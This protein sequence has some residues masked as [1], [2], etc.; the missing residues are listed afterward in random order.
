[1][2]HWTRH[3]SI[4]GRTT[5][6]TLCAAMLA[7]NIWGGQQVVAAELDG[8]AIGSETDMN[9]LS[10]QELTPVQLSNA[11]AGT[12]FVQF[13]FT[14]AEVGDSKDQ[15]ILGYNVY[16]AE[17]EGG[18]ELHD[19]YV[20][21]GKDIKDGKEAVLSDKI[22]VKTAVQTSQTPQ[23]EVPDLVEGM[24]IPQGG[25]VAD[26][27]PG[28]LEVVDVSGETKTVA[29]IWTDVSN[30]DIS[31]PGSYTVTVTLEGW[32]DPLTKTV[33]VV[34]NEIK[35]YTSP[36]D[37]VVVQ[38]Q[39]LEG[40]LPEKVK[41]SYTNTTTGELAVT[42]DISKVD[43]GKVGTY[44][45]TG[46]LAT[47]LGGLESAPTITIKVVATDAKPDRIETLADITVK[48]GEKII[49]PENVNVI[50]SDG[51][52]IENGVTW[53]TFNPDKAGT[54]TVNGTLTPAIEGFEEKPQ[55]R[56]IVTT[57]PVGYE[58]LET[59]QVNKGE[60]PV[61]PTEVT[62]KFTDGTTKKLTV[63]WPE[64]DTSLVGTTVVTADALSESFGE[65]FKLPE[66]TIRVIDPQGEKEPLDF[67][68]LAPVSVDF[69]TSKAD[70]KTM[71]KEK[72]PTVTL[73]YSDG[74]KEQVAVSWD[75]AVDADTFSTSTKGTYTYT[76]NGALTDAIEG[77]SLQPS[78]VVNII[79][80]PVRIEALEA[81]EV[82]MGTAF[83]DIDQLPSEVTIV[84]ADDSTQ[85]AAVTW[86]EGNYD[87]ETEGEYELTGDLATPIDGFAEIPSI[88]VKVVDFI[89]SVEEVA[90]EAGVGATADEVMPKEV[91]ATW[92]SGKTTKVAVDWSEGLGEV[93]FD[94]VGTY[95]AT[96][97]VVGYDGEVTAAVTVIYPVVYQFDFGTEG[98]AVAEGWTGVKVNNAKATKPLADLG[99]VYS[100]AQGYGFAIDNK[101]DGRVDAGF[102]YDG[103]ASIPQNVYNDCALVGVVDFPVNLKNGKY[104]VEIISTTVSLGTDKNYNNRVSADVEG[105]RLEVSSSSQGARYEVGGTEVTVADNQ[106]N[107][108]FQN[109]ASSRVAGIIIRKMGET[110]NTKD[111]VG[112]YPVEV[113]KG[114]SLSTVLPNTVSVFAKGS[115]GKPQQVA[116]TWDIDSV[117]TNTLGD[118]E[119]TGTLQNPPAGISAEPKITVHVVDYA[120][121]VK[122]VYVEV[123]KD[124]DAESVKNSLPEMVDVVYAS[125]EIKQLAVTWGEVDSSAVGNVEVSG[126]LT[127]DNADENRN[128]V[129]AKASVS[130]AYKAVGR[131]DFGTVPADGWTT[132]QDSD[133]E[134]TADRKYGFTQSTSIILGS[135]TFTFAG[136]LPESVY[137]DYAVI[138]NATFQVDVPN[139]RYYVELSASTGNTAKATIQ[140]TEVSVTADA[141]KYAVNG[142]E[143]LVEN[144]H[145]SITF[146]EEAKVNSIVVREIEQLDLSATPVKFVE[147]EAVEVFING[148]PEL[149]GTILLEYSDNTQREVEVSWNTV[150][151]SAIGITTVKGSLKAPIDGFT[152]EPEIKVAVG[153][154]F[155]FGAS[156]VQ[157]GWIQ[158]KTASDDYETNGKYGFTSATKT[159]G[160]SDKS[161]NLDGSDALD[162]VYKDCVLGWN[163]T[164]TFEYAVKVPN[165]SYNVTVYTYNGSGQ[166]Y[167]LFTIEGVAVGDIRHGN[168]DLAR[169]VRNVTVEVTDG[170][171]NVTC[172]SSKSNTP[173]IYFSGLTVVPAAENSA[174]IASAISAL[175]L[176]AMNCE[177]QENEI[178]L[179]E[180]TVT[181]ATFVEI[182]TGYRYTDTKDV[183]PDTT[184]SYKV[185]AVV[186]ETSAVVD[187][188]ALQKAVEEAE[189]LTDNQELYTEESW[190]VFAEKLQNAKA[191]L[192]KEDATAEEV[193]AARTEL[194]DAQNALTEIP[195][196]TEEPTTPPEETEEPT[197]PPE[198]TEEPTT[199]P[200]ETEEPTT[201]PEETEEPTTPPEET[202]EPTTP[203]EE[204]EEP[205]TPPEETEE[206][207]TPPEETEEPTTPPE[208]SE[209]PTTPPVPDSS[210]PPTSDINDEKVNDAVQELDKVKEETEPEKV[211]ESVKQIFSN[212]KDSVLGT[213]NEKKE[214]IAEAVVKSLQSLKELEERLI[215]GNDGERKV[216]VDD[217][218]VEPV[219][220]IQN[221]EFNVIPGQEGKILI[222]DDN[223]KEKPVNLN[224]GTVKVFS[225]TLLVRESSESEWVRQPSKE[226]DVPMYITMDVPDG[227]DTSKGVEIFHIADGSNDWEAQGDGILSENGR[228]VS[229]VASGFS[230]YAIAAKAEAAT[231]EATSEPDT[232]DDAESNNDEE[233]SNAPTSP[234]TYDSSGD[235]GKI[236]MIILFMAVA[237]VLISG[238]AVYRKP[239]RDK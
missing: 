226:F 207:T 202:E 32:S 177:S 238:I 217:E 183:K 227:I 137:Q 30:V 60:K 53:E 63:T 139:G 231:P 216:Q 117:N 146:T 133:N 213:A 8:V 99:S 153:Y 131:Y 69:G 21:P 25:T 66:I 29:A 182:E 41:V 42:W 173:A 205:T 77:F 135:D 14:E 81:I 126:T 148:T 149:P 105:T 172:K 16:R 237:A 225:F 239:K 55:I 192:M 176:A 204:T 233:V 188:T 51:T 96:G 147:P 35:S 169:E 140:G 113:V 232:G 2:K 163:A 119:V 191:V 221:T 98:S 110:D 132:V 160:Y 15:E 129:Q 112:N 220:E 127:V 90:V 209:N 59:V 101:M 144:G 6:L 38:G 212:L 65:D 154:G 171:L 3:A 181:T 145:L 184:Y 211:F 197:T 104:Y 54:Y 94:V 84:Y 230:S 198:E 124:A 50:Y 71:L 91:S 44:T 7:G 68:N 108:M 73:N 79:V 111:E 5:A 162:N 58:E 224:V 49:L 22:T 17:G 46:T 178:Q 28:T 118:I 203:P 208:E 157:D 125:G 47:T 179:L 195:E 180:D 88:K 57:E 34:P 36:E 174:T 61:L 120:E 206:P 115:D 56:V 103:N 83:N 152:L 166:Q 116:V 193:E 1:M 87:S 156:T 39:T 45:V 187:K 236:M 164:E 74:S 48:F 102:V 214:K 26:L 200:E 161:Y 159:L 82:P 228:K 33:K 229:F 222:E 18:Y 62:V 201:P 167:N 235:V 219:V 130:V 85:K 20:L 150:E 9:S 199:P 10:T 70:V 218:K 114:K 27:L 128:N 168:T 67:T 43:T 97:K 92:K 143:A 141:D 64:V 109:T 75:A 107:I 210:T 190:A 136:L 13:D 12:D 194:V 170:E 215:A 89:V 78:L 121:S 106:L 24:P 86:K 76:L 186:K 158:I 122:P 95:T 189:A 185:A 19:T 123:E 40:K 93:D 138:A 23:F 196:E 151:T 80:N 4:F 175:Q 234:K 31:K 155:D 37:V 165:G 223:T 72:V 142:C 134:Y 100:V 11:V 52:K